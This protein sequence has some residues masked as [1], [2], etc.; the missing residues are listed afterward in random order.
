MACASVRMTLCRQGD[1]GAC[2]GECQGRGTIFRMI[3]V[4]TQGECLKALGRCW[5][6]AHGKGGAGAAAAK[7]D[8]EYKRRSKVKSR[9]AACMTCTEQWVVA[10]PCKVGQ[11][12]VRTHRP[13]LARLVAA[14]SSRLAPQPRRITV[15]AWQS[16]CSA[17]LPLSTRVGPRLHECEQE[18]SRHMIAGA[19]AWP[20]GVGAPAAWCNARL[21]CF[22][23]CFFADTR[24]VNTD[25]QA[26]C[27]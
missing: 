16:A 20:R 8:L 4:L 14:G 15:Y 6:K 22:N 7:A 12:P 25:T 11:P 17:Q 10:R 5:L 21:L 19:S 24:T 2:S 23:A 9:T 26:R 1:G 27:D 3:C 18:G 13:I